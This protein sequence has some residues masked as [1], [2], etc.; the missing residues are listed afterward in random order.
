MGAAEETK[1]IKRIFLFGILPFII[2]GILAGKMAA[3]Q[4]GLSDDIRMKKGNIKRFYDQ[5]VNVPEQKSIDARLAE[6]EEARSQV[7]SLANFNS[8]RLPEVPSDITEPGVYFKEKLYLTQKDLNNLGSNFK[9][10]VPGN[11]GFTEKLPEESEV[12]VLLMKLDL[13]DK[14]LRILI[15]N[16]A[17]SIHLVEFLESSRLRNQAEKEMPVKNISARFDASCSFKTLRKALYEIGNLNPFLVVEGLKVT[18]NQNEIMDV[19]FHI[20]QLLQ[21]GA[22]G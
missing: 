22:G 16:S 18:Q 20:T 4:K 2:Y 13:A 21:E 3:T 6:I 15:E 12:P 7:G 14:V 1:K 19:S 9:V 17:K 5:G 11:I 10:T 8:S